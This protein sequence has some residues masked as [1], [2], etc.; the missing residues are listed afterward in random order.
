MQHRARLVQHFL[1]IEAL[2]NQPRQALVVRPI[3]HSAGAAQATEG[4][5]T[6]L[7]P[8]VA[9]AA[10]RVAGRL[11]GLGLTGARIAVVAGARV[12]AAEPNLEVWPLAAERGVAELVEDVRQLAAFDLDVIIDFAGFGTTTAGAISAVRPGGRVVVVGLGRNEATISTAELVYKSVTLR[13]SRGGPPGALESVLALMANGDLT[14][15]AT[16]IG[17]DEIPDAIERLNSGHVVGRIAAVMP[18]D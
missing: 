5:P 8:S 2:P 14:I 3:S 15:H 11:G 9:A 7:P 13:G 18:D 17:F 16:R 4:S 12:Y 10:S 1:L 6:A